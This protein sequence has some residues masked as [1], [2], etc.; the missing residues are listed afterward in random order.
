MTHP[1]ARTSEKSRSG[2]RGLRDQTSV[3]LTIVLRTSLSGPSP[4]VPSSPRVYD[5][6]GNPS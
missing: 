1:N 5:P 6:P 4:V 2:S 3:G